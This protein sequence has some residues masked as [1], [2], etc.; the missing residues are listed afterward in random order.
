MFDIHIKLGLEYIRYPS[1]D[2][3]HTNVKRQ[4]SSTDHLTFIVQMSN[5]KQ[6]EVPH[7]P[8]WTVECQ[9]QAV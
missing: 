1:F 3:H 8:H 4:M 6:F 2:V 5:I 7:L 9:R